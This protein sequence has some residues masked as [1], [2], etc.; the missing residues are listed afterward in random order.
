MKPLSRAATYD[1]ALKYIAEEL[2]MF[3]Q[4]NSE[5]AVYWMM[6]PNPMLGDTVPAWL[7]LSH[8]EGPKKLVRFIRECRA[9]DIA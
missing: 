8:P 5:K 6:T 7:M 1:E 2:G 3:F 4:G 9:G